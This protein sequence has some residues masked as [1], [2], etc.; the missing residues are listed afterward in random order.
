[1]QYIGKNL[2]PRL[3]HVS[4]TPPSS[5]E[6]LSVVH[7]DLDPCLDL[8]GRLEHHMELSRAIEGDK[9]SHKELSIGFFPAPSRIVTHGR[10]VHEGIAGL[11]ARRAQEDLD[12]EFGKTRRALERFHRGHHSAPRIGGAD[13]AGRQISGGE[14]ATL[15]EAIISIFIVTKCGREALHSHVI[16]VIPT[17]RYCVQIAKQ[18]SAFDA[19]CPPLVNL[20]PVRWILPY[21]MRKRNQGHGALGRHLDALNQPGHS[22]AQCGG[23]F[24]IREHSQDLSSLEARRGFGAN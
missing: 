6:G 7:E 22:I 12:I 4:E 1:M 3:L 20:I 15:G 9:E 2:P 8:L 19:L 14:G 11:R 13:G 17:D 18:G 10:R 16:A 23:R 5:P 24:L 21:Q